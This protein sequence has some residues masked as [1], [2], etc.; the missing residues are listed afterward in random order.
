[1]TEIMLPTDENHT[2]VCCL[3]SMNL[4]KYDEWKGTDAVFYAILFLDAV[5]SEFIE[6][7]KKIQGIEDAV[8]FAEKS[9]ALG[10]GALGY[11][12]YL[13]SKQIPFISISANAMT[14][15][16]FGRMREQAESATYELFKDYDAPE[17]CEGQTR[18]NL[19]LLA[20]AP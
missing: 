9:R 12:T 14:R 10:L 19:T 18:R 15:I 2:L 3:S 13:Q 6:K 20:I 7:A 17:W 8:R 4:A 1:M 16:I 11:H 5:I